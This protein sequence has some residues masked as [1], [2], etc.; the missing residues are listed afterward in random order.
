MK[1]SFQKVNILKINDLKMCYFLNI[2]NF[3]I[4]SQNKT[5]KELK[6]A[7]CYFSLQTSIK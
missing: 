6:L 5:I 4:F 2:L 1:Y 7:D 3:G